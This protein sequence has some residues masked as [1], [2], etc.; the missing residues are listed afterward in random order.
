MGVAAA[1]LIGGCDFDD[2]RTL[3]PPTHPLP[4][5]TVATTTLPTDIDAGAPPLASTEPVAVEPLDLT[6]SWPD[7][8]DLPDRHGCAG[9]GISPALSWSGIPAGTVE[10]A[11][12]LTDLDAG[13][14]TL[15]V[16]E[17]IA[18]TNGGFGE[19]AVPVEAFERPNSSG[20]TGYE[21][22]CPPAGETH[23]VQFTLHALGQQLELANDATADEVI[24][25]LDQIA[26]GQASV[27]SFAT[28]T[29]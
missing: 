26:I 22:P 6:A 5:V 29:G 28:G 10:L 7:G 21:P 25:F 3:D 8:G 18:P 11:L 14:A 15:W 20:A 17:G 16:I 12:T 19:G 2:G 1:A 23:L 4:P 27:S 9:E 24:A 13:I